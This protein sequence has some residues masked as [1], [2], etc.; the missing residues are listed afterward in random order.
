MLKIVQS[1]AP[2]G[3]KDAMCR[4]LAVIGSPRSEPILK[5][6]LK[7]KDTEAMARHALHGVQ[8]K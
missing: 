4:Q 5:A 1:K 8:M 7:N 6:M 2:P 3:A